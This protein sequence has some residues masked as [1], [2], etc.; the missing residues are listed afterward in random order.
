MKKQYETEREGQMAFFD[1][2]GVDYQND[3]SILVDNTDGVYN[4]NLFE[5]K[6]N[7]SDVNKV[8]FQAVKYLSK[9][10]VRGESVPATILLVSLNDSMVYMFHSRDYIKEIQITYTGGASL[11]NQGFI[12]KS[13][14]TEINYSTYA[15]SSIVKKLIKGRK[16]P[17]S[18]YDESKPNENYEFVPIDIDESCIVGWG[19]RYYREL[20][21]AS[22]GDFLGDDTGMQVKVTGEIREPKHFKGLIT[23]YMKPTNEKFKYLMDCLNDRLSKKD[24]GAFYT[25]MPYC[26]KASELVMKAVERVPEGNDYIILDRCAGTG[27]LESAL[28]GKYDKNG[29]ELISHCVVS[30]YEYYEYKVLAERIGD[31]VR[32]IIPP[33]EANVV[34]ENGKVSNAD[35]MSKEFIDNPLIKQYVDNPKCTIILFEN[36]PYSDEVSGNSKQRGKQVKKSYVFNNCFNSLKLFRNSS[37]ATA[38]DLSN[39]FIWSGFHYYLRQDTDSYI[40]FSPIKYWKTIG[41]INKEILNGFMFNRAYFH[42]TASAITCILWSNKESEVDKI[43]LSCVDIHNDKTIEIKKVFHQKV[44]NSFSDKY[45]DSKIRLD[46]VECGVFCEADGEET[47]GR[48]CT[49][50]SFYNKSIIG[51]L[52]ATALAVNAQQRYLT[53]QKIFNAA[54]FYLRIENY[55]D[56]LPLFVSKLFPQDYWYEKDVYFTTSDGGDAYTKDK[57]F[58]KYCLI[59]TCLSNQNKC[60]SFTG[61]DGRYYRNELCFDTSDESNLPLAFK[62]LMEYNCHD[63][64]ALDNDENELLE[65]WFKILTEARQTENYDKTKTYGVYQITKEL[66]TF[67]AEGKGKTKKNVYDYPEL[68]GDLNSLRDKL[69]EYYKSHITEKMFKYELLK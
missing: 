1:N 4:G 22:K 49:G 46:D 29:S 21:N 16:I 67:H 13:E 37:I 17:P 48:K 60:L 42:A 36:P 69:K 59:Y 55:L 54:G 35:A 66:N 50:K 12:R 56:K 45:Y 58:L 43:K 9:M 14:P 62:D 44:Y 68:N 39:Q 33:T 5:F 51:Y 8:L 19:E 27:N 57:D 38:R 47:T 31:K 3:D 64:T 65:L 20:P 40:V 30:T 11:N 32:N 7:I 25:P 61:S 28:I 15:G 52:R 53:R 2:Y 10:R 18:K 24:L 23:P 6:L 34:Y 41:L 63:E 26:E